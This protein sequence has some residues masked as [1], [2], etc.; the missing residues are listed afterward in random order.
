[1]AELIQLLTTSQQDFTH[2]Q[3]QGHDMI[4]A[5]AAQLSSYV[6]P[7]SAR[8]DTTRGRE[9]ASIH[10]TSADA[11]FLITT[12]DHDFM[13][14]ISVLVFARRT[15]TQNVTSVRAS[16]ER[17]AAYSTLAASSNKS[18]TDRSLARKV[19]DLDDRV[20][21]P[22]AASVEGGVGSGSMHMEVTIEI[23]K[24]ETS[25][26]AKIKD[27][28]CYTWKDDKVFTGFVFSWAVHVNG[29][30]LEEYGRCNVKVYEEKGCKG[31]PIADIKNANT[32]NTSAGLCWM[33]N[34]GRPGQSVSVGCVEGKTDWTGETSITPPYTPQPEGAEW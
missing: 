30:Q 29:E 23:G 2:R 16:K 20:S 11:S 31:H 1:M 15:S 3:V 17:K 26:G 33:S 32:H 28:Q 18:A 8:P 34:R 9:P 21:N 5:H 10:D 19:V 22:D 6:A 12:R 27:G 7:S 4:T 24:N 25:E 14:V 13:S